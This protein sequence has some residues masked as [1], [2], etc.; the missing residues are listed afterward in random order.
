MKSVTLQELES[1][2][3]SIL[4]RVAQGE[5]FVVTRDDAD[6]AELRPRHRPALAA[7]ELIKRR[8][9]LPKVDLRLLR[10]DIDAVLDGGT[11]IGHTYDHDEH[12][13]GRGQGSSV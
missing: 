4:D 10:R 3:E 13:A 5:E 7:A 8:R 6:V 9:H 12:V 11:L 2:C 1:D